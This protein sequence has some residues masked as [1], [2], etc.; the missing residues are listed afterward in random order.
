MRQHKNLTDSY[1][2]FKE[3]FKDTTISKSDYVKIAGAFLKY[4]M[5]RVIYNSDTVHLPFKT[6]VIEVIGLR[7]KITIGENGEIK[8]L[9]P[10]WK[11]TKELYEKCPECKEKR[12]IVYNT[13]EHTDGIRYKFNW[14]LRNMVMKNKLYYVLK[15]TRENKRNLYRAILNGQEYE[16]R[17]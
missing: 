16:V 1:T 3:R 12:Q 14:G 11:K 2:L 7:S 5:K 8:G 15:M 17:Q 9:S 10:N 6:G 13:N 4:I